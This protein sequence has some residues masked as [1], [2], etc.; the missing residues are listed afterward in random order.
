MKLIFEKSSVGR[1]AVELP[2]FEYKKADK[3]VPKEF[4]RDDVNLPE[5][6]EID[7][8]RHYTELS[9]RNFG[10]DN[11]FYPLGSCTMKYNPKINEDVSRFA[12]FAGLHPLADDGLSQGSLQLLYEMR[13]YLCEIIG[14]KGFTLQPAAGAHGELTSVMITKKYFKDLKED[15]KII[16]IPDSAHGTNPA[17]AAH[18]G[19]DVVEVKSDADGNVDLAELERLLTK[20]VAALMLT[21]PNTLGLFDSNVTKIAEMLHENGSLLYMDGANM[22]AMLGVVR[23]GDLGADLIQLNLHKSFSTPHGCGGPGSGPVG[24]SKNLVKY[25]PNPVVK[26][27]DDKYYLDF[28]NKESIGK[29]HAFQGNFGVIVKAYTYIRKLGAQGLKDA[30][31]NSVLSANYL[32]VKLM[33]DYNLPYKRICAHEFVLNDLDMPNHVTTGDIAKRLLDYGIHAP[34]IY[35]PMIV[36]GAIMIEPTETESIQTM[37]RFVDVMKKI[38]KEAKENPDLVR[39]APHNLFVKKLDGVKAARELDVKYWPGC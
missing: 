26:K 38:K 17:S 1:T 9:R 20:D 37:D 3:K 31:E 14:M 8:I 10:V 29:V 18:C 13:E 19:F 35:F 21:F 16:L 4:L 5:L 2:D 11:G 15:R 22:N 23:P 12:G 24:V 39:N 36:H 30:G 25:L 27:K 6:A 33:H 7:V 28:K 32:R 34:T